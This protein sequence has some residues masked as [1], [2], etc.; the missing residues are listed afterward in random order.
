[1]A[2]N[3]NKNPAN[4]A[5]N[6]EGTEKTEKADSKSCNTGNC[7][8]Y[9]AAATKYSKLTLKAVGKFAGDLFKS[10][11]QSVSEISDDIK[12]QADKEDVKP[13]EKAT[14]QKDKN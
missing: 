11:K 3:E 7:T 4:D 5:E 14:E 9:V 8:D 13:A 10:A 12:Q 6:T 1:M 2:D